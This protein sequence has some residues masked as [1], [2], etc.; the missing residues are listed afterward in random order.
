MLRTLAGYAAAV[1]LCL[2]VLTGVM[3]LW[4]RDLAIPF[5][6]LVDG[7]SV[8]TW[9]KGTIE[10]GWYWLNPALGA[11]G[12][13]EF[14]DFPMVET[15]HV[16]L[17]KLLAW[18]CRDY[19]MLANLY[20]LLTFPLTTLSSLWVLRRWA[21]SWGPAVLVSLLYAFL[22]YHFE[23]GLNHLF[24]AA[25]YLIP[26]ATLVM[27]W[28]YHDQGVL[29]HPD[30]P[31]GRLRLR[32]FGF[33]SVA[34][35]IICL[36]V[37][38]A[39]WYYAAFTGFF[40]MVAGAAAGFARR[41]LYPLL[42]AGILYALML[43]SLGIN[44]LP[45][46][47]FVRANGHNPVG[48]KRSP[49]ETEAY[50]LKIGHLLLP[51]DSHR[52]QNVHQFFSHK[53]SALG[54]YLGLIAGVGFVVLVGRFI[55]RGRGT[56]QHSGLLTA[57]CLLNGCGVLLATVSG[58][59]YVFSWLV[60]PTIRCY[61]RMSVF[62]GFFAL[63]AV[64][65]GLARLGRRLDTGPLRRGVFYTLLAG[66]LA[67][68]LV[69]QVPKPV[70]RFY[71]WYCQ[72]FHEDAAF[73]GAIEAALPSGAMVFQLPYSPW[74]EPG[75]AA[76][77]F[78]YE[79]LRPYLHSRH[80]HW[81]YGAYKGREWDEWQQGVAELPVDAMV[82]KLALAGFEAVYLDRS[83]CRDGG[84]ALEAALT[85]VLGPTRLRTADGKRSCFPMRDYLARLNGEVPASAR[86]ALRQVA[87]YP[88]RAQ[89]GE[90]FS[91]VEGTADDHFRWCASTGEVHVVNKLPFPRTVA[92]DMEF[93]ITQPQAAH[94]WVESEWFAA[95]LDLTP[96]QRAPLQRTV[97]VPPGQHTLRFRC[98]APPLKIPAPR[99][100][101]FQLRNFRLSDVTP[102]E[103]PGLAQVQAAGAARLR[104]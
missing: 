96:E 53:I 3:R 34:S 99:V 76:F 92:L 82:R 21:I 2:A 69:D 90:G 10:S 54:V 81:S 77:G 30:G 19:G 35:V 45:V 100:M 33:E 47:Q 39:G 95:R 71:D 86:D 16:A 26:P 4:K 58:F 31:D 83:C 65:V 51:G 97:V 13:S 59:S 49:D 14:F 93:I 23:R 72:R 5:V 25:Y 91:Y 62:L 73:V 84:A 68:G 18:V 41:R 9:V 66:L 1:L 24:L 48:L 32:P 38:M 20:F 15:L 43:L 57:L 64:A 80:L 46:Y 28:V 87:L 8:L 98:D 36:L 70:V 29:L 52:L 63:V 44:L 75:E 79:G 89:W 103:V 60:T 17:I 78:P 74:P 22:P 94:L 12:T 61:Y 50:G 27:Y 104:P 6:Y 102:E 55:F 85:R 7:L 37:S 11:P 67:F 42:T 56:G 88:V 40:L 101:V